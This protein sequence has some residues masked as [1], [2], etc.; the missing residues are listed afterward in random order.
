ML[1][2]NGCKRNLNAGRELRNHAF[3]VERNDFAPAVGIIVGQKAA[4]GGETVACKG[5]VDVD[6]ENVNLEHI[7]R[8]GFLD[9]D[10]SGEN[11]ASR[12]LI[13]HFA[14]DIG[15][16]GGNIRGSH[17]LLDQPLGRPAG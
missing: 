14:I 9:G 15:V 12:A 6:F 2:K 7:A 16:I 4:A 5:H 3:A 13:L 8:L 17:A 11:V 1:P 10:R